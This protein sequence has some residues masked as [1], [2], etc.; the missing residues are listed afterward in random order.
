M[1]DF[2]APN[3]TN[4]FGLPPS[5]ANYIEPGKKPLSSM[6]PSIIVDEYGDVKLIIGAAGGTKITTTIA[7]VTMRHLFYGYPL[8]LAIDAKRIHHQLFPMSVAAEKG[9]DEVFFYDVFKN[10]HLMRYFSCLFCSKS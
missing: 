4:S 8:K 2:A 6:C 7:L 9:F 10:K 5:P 1:D 3:I